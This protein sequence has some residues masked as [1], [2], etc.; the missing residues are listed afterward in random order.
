MDGT[1]PLVN[2]AGRRM[3]GLGTHEQ[4]GAM[5]KGGFCSLL[6]GEETSHVEAG[7]FSLASPGLRS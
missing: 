7:P 2:A 1:V 3:Q 5:C 6:S 4:F